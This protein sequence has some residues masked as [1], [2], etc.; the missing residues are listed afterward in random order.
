MTPDNK[1][2]SALCLSFFIL[3]FAFFAAQ[4]QVGPTLGTWGTTSLG[5]LYASFAGSAFIAPSLLQYLTP[6]L[7]SDSL[8]AEVK[9]LTFG[10]VLYAPYLFSCSLGNKDSIRWFQLVSSGILGIGA[11]LLWVSQGSLLTSSCTPSNRG[12][13]SGFFWASFM[14][15]NAAGNYVTAGALDHVSVSTVFLGLT[16]VSLLSSATLCVCLRPRTSEECVVRSNMNVLREPLAVVEHEK[17]QEQ[18][19]SREATSEVTLS[20]PLG[21]GVRE[22]ITKLLSALKTPAVRTLL[23]LLLFIGCE[24]SFWGGAFPDVV[25]KRFGDQTV[26]LVSGVLATFDIVASIVSGLLLDVYKIDSRILLFFGILALTTGS[27]LVW[28]EKNISEV[29]KGSFSSSIWM[30]YIAASCMGVGD[31]VCNTVAITR[32]QILSVNHNL[33]SKRT[34]F[35][36]F[37]CVNVGMTAVTFVVLSNFPANGSN[38]VWYILESLALCSLLCLL[39]G[40]RVAYK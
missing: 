38:C 15:G 7:R 12:R 6:S 36:L 23:A 10:S 1:R 24:N 29:T 9:T 13:W 33:M 21:S 22:D 35:Q 30:S 2:L 34:A 28:M 5:I 8:S 16:G 32:L 27:I 4:N 25:S 14:L 37:Q 20:L 18:T 39:V 31:G 17:Q 26:A 3:F 11:G 40:T 19:R